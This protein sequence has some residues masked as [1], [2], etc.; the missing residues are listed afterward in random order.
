MLYAYVSP[1]NC[2]VYNM[3]L[4]SRADRKY[5]NWCG[6]QGDP[7]GWHPICSPHPISFMYRG[8]SLSLVYV[9]GLLD[10]MG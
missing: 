2:R 8:L 9:R 5:L 3:T 1:Y 6:F 4:Y 10:L 7:G